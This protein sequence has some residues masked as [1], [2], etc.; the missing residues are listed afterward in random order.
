MKLMSLIFLVGLFLTSSE[1]YAR[2]CRGCSFRRVGPI[3]RFIQNRR[4]ARSCRSCGPSRCG[5]GGC[6]GANMASNPN[7]HIGGAP[8]IPQGSPAPGAGL[9]P[10][11]NASQAPDGISERPTQDPDVA[12]APSIPPQDPDVAEAPSLPSEAQ[13]SP[14]KEDPCLDKLEKSAKDELAAVDI[15]KESAQAQ[16][17]ARKFLEI[18]DQA[19]KG[20]SD[21]P[22]AD[23][24]KRMFYFLDQIAKGDP[25]RDKDSLWYR[26]QG[27]PKPENFQNLV[28]ALKQFGASQSREGQQKALE[29]STEHLGWLTSRSLGA[30]GF[31][32]HRHFYERSLSWLACLKKN[33]PPKPSEAKAAATKAPE[34]KPAQPQEPKAKSAPADLKAKGAQ[35][36]QNQCLTC[37]DGSVKGPVSSATA[38]LKRVLSPDPRRRMPQGGDAIVGEELEALKAYLNEYHP[39]AQ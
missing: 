37:H 36:F 31:S 25:T 13:G 28:R 27:M 24:E 2:P 1:V 39:G 35:V 7:D 21:F 15:K 20:H 26:D 9:N 19:K 30:S 12:E 5:N 18:L 17:N 23:P 6:G 29:A 8:N 33:E 3:R 11:Q 34:E 38:A 10:A 4:A 32:E 16:E 14:S 22:E